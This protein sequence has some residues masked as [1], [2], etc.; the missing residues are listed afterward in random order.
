MRV[1]RESQPLRCA[2]AF[3][4]GM[5]SALIA[6]FAL[7]VANSDGKSQSVEQPKTVFAVNDAT[8]KPI[9]SGTYMPLYLQDDVQWSHVD[10]AGGTIGDSGCGLVCASMAI[11]Y[12]TTQDVT[13][14]SLADAVGDACLTDGV[15]DA[16]KLAQWIAATYEEYGIEYSGKIY[17]FRLSIDQIEG[18]AV[19]LAGVRGAFGDSF[20]GSHIVLI[21][22]PGNGDSWF[23]RDP[24]SPG[25]SSRPWTIE[26]LTAADIF[27]SACIKGGHYGST[28]N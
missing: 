25:N 14:M 22:K 16:G 21:W 1:S 2:L 8:C 4:C 10:Y 27:Y 11:K 23:V 19:C 28:G 24:A 6:C 20:Y 15:S 3:M 17:D 7:I 26:E 13:P 9:P 5:L 18:G 12:L